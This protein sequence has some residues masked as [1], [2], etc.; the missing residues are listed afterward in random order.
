MMDIS[1]IIVSYNVKE[2]IIS[3]I[4]S[5]YKHSKSNHSFEIIVIDNNSKD[6]TTDSLEKEFPKISL[7]KNK[8]NAGFSIA[9]NQGVKSCQ[10]KYIFILN[11]DTLIVED[12][13]G[14]LINAAKNQK[15]LGALGP[16]LVDDNEVFQQSFWRNPSIINTLLSIFHLDLLNYK[17]NYKD[18]RFNTISNVETISGAALFLP[19]TTFNKLNGFNEKLFW[20]EDVDLCFR[21]NQLGYKTYYLPLTK[22]VHF[23]GKSAETNYKVAISNQLL[24]K[25]KFFRIHHSK[26]SANIILFSVLLISLVKSILLLFISPFSSLYRRKMVAYLY[27]IR[28]VFN[29]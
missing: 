28:S 19:R 14:K 16:S 11:P 24:S 13:L 15:K 20:M 1:I 7:I 2:Y 17:K 8:Y 10:G 12:V 29:S 26:L 9:A 23:S 5:I 18:K 22:I 21:L 27:T 6:G 25:I 3:C 4:E